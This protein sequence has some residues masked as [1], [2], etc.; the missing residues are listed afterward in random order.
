MKALVAVE[1]E[2]SEKTDKE[3]ATKRL[4][5]VISVVYPGAV[6][7]HKDVPWVKELIVKK[8]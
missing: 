7:E 3:T 1:P 8:K 5:R 2:V 6:L 4:V